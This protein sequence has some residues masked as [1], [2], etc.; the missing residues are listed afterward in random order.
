MEVRDLYTKKALKNPHENLLGTQVKCL[1]MWGSHIIPN[2]DL[3]NVTSPHN[4]LVPP[5]VD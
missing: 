3:V 1:G 4:V 2:I 5:L